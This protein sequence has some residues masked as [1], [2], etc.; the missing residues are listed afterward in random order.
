MPMVDLTCLMVATPC[1]VVFALNAE[2]LRLVS[3]ISE[4]LQIRFY[5]DNQKLM[6]RDTF[7]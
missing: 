2:L 4:W 7:K 1:A 6:A 5:T 3:T